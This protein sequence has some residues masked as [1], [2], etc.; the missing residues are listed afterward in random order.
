MIER[1]RE[2]KEKNAFVMQVVL[3]TTILF[4]MKADGKS[5]DSSLR[6]PCIPHILLDFEHLVLNVS[7][8]PNQLLL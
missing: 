1:E 7:L 2:E 3:Y 6:W 8:M 5:K 4:F